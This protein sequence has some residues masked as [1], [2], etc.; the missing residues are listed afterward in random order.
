MRSKWVTERTRLLNQLTDV[1]RRYY[2]QILD[3]GDVHESWVHTL[4]RKVPTPDAA[5]RVK[6]RA[7]QT[8]LDKHRVRKVN[9]DDVVATLRTKALTL[10]ADLVAVLAAHTLQ[11]V[12]QLDNN[13]QHVDECDAAIKKL[14]DA[15]SASDKPKAPPSDAA[16]LNSIPGVGIVV[17]ST[18][19][20]EGASAIAA[21]DLQRMRAITGC[22]PVSILSGKRQNRYHARSGPNVQMRYARND[23]LADAAY[24]MARIASVFSEPHKARYRAMR[25]R[26]HTHGRACR[27]LADQM[28][29]TIFAMLRD[30]TLYDENKITPKAA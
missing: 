24:H 3:V 5:Q 23:R 26:G 10:N 20:G 2:P 21:R 15:L 12:T 11:L 1:L 29:T 14:L 9:A 13:E 6:S 19:L 30:R 25:S 16:I 28:L 7:V 27:Q 22:A 17:A 18:M 8:L 4:L